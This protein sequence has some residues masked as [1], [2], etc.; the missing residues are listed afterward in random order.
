[1]AARRPTSEAF[2]KAVAPQ[3]AAISVGKDN[4]YGLPSDQTLKLLKAQGI[5]YWRTDEV[6]SIVFCSD[7]KTVTQGGERITG[8]GAEG[9]PTT[10][11]EPRAE[12][13]ASVTITAVDRVAEIVTLMN[14]DSEAVDLSGWGVGQREGRPTV[15]FPQRDDPRWRQDTGSDLR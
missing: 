2:L 10:E 5:P 15:Y 1:M 8:S 3:W 9:L 12:K 4:D 11:N 14:T 6:G 13:T 7:G